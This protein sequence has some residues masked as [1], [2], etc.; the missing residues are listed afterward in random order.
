MNNKNNK[1]F[2]LIEFIIL[3]AII[4]VLAA[5]AVPNYPR[6]GR[7]LGRRKACASNIRV[8]Q[9]AVEM[10]NMDIEGGMPSLNLDLLVKQG[11]LR[12]LPTPPE[13][14]CK[15]FSI[16]DI[17]VEEKGVIFCEYHGDM[18]DFK[19]KPGMTYYDYLDEKKRL[20][21]EKER[22]EFEKKVMQQMT[23]LLII[24]G[25]IGGI[26]IFSPKKKAKKS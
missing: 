15:Y 26:I 22:K 4:G 16:G 2:T 3:I 17:S 24:G 23:T 8:I 18:E 5:M 20:K 10:Y 11:Y 1:G 6:H 14:E 9:G 21:E 7:T 12:A 25:I 19:I 13:R